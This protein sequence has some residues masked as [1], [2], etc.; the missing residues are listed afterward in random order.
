M[1]PYLEYCNSLVTGLTPCAVRPQK[2]IQ[3]AAGLCPELNVS[4][5]VLLLNIAFKGYVNS[6]LYCASGLAMLPMI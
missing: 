4:M 2:L 5:K 1:L 3:N 6:D